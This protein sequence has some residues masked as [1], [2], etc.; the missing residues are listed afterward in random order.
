MGLS[1]NSLDFFV[2]FVLKFCRW[3]KYF[4][5]FIVAKL[6]HGA[7]QW[8]ERKKVEDHKS[9]WISCLFVLIIGVRRLEVLCG[10]GCMS[11][12]VNYLVF[13][14]FYPAC[15]ALVLEVS[16]YS[17][18][19]NFVIHHVGYQRS[20]NQ[21]FQSDTLSCFYKELQLFNYFELKGWIER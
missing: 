18:L 4:G 2:E 14:T 3:C 13:M 10:Y 5:I 6:L 21:L 15:L 17:T 20:K 12:V 9:D 11:A 16:Y 7:S 8:I 19:N 1:C